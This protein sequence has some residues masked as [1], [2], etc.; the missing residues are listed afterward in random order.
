[1]LMLLLLRWRCRGG[2]DFSALIKMQ[3][4]HG[5]AQSNAVLLGVTKFVVLRLVAVLVVPC[6]L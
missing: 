1:M 3:L 4:A 5:V 6:M 2:G